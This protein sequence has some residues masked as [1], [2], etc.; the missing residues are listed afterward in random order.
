MPNLFSVET[1]FFEILGYP[2]SYI[3]VVGTVLYFASVWLIARKNPLTWPVGIISVIL[4][5][6]LFFQFSLYSD[7]LE[8]IYYLIASAYGW[9]A[10]SRGAKG[11]EVVTGF[12]SPRTI[13]TWAAVTLVFGVALGLVMG[14]VHN[15]WPVLFPA[16]AALPML[17]A[18]T[19]VMSLAAMWL[20]TLKRAESWIYWIIVDIAAIYVYFTKEIVFIGLQYVVLTGMAIYGFLRWRSKNQEGNSSR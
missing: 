5:M 14:E 11:E 8:Q 17:D 12:S 19:T 2:V 9:W 15:W 18:I 13:V 16:S 20:L 10:W 1:T 4:Y 3:E 6:V 7:F